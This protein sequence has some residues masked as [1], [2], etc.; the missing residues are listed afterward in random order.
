MRC[1]SRRSIAIGLVV[2]A[3]AACHAGSRAGDVAIDARDVTA[4][5]V[6]EGALMLQLLATARVDGQ[7]LPCG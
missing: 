6:P 2:L 1:S 7:V 3:G 5:G 4:R